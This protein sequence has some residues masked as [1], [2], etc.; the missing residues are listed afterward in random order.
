MDNRRKSLVFVALTQ[1][2][3]PSNAAVPVLLLGKFSNLQLIF[4]NSVAGFLLMLL[5][6]LFQK[7]QDIIVSYAKDMKIL[8]RLMM[9]GI[10]GISLYLIFLYQAYQLLNI[11]LAYTINLLWPVMT[12]VISI[13]LLKDKPK[14]KQILG[15]LI[16]FSGVLLVISEG[17]LDSFGVTNWWGIL[18][19]LTGATCYGLYSVLGKKWDYDRPVSTL[20]FYLSSMLFTGLALIITQDIDIPPITILDIIGFIWV[21]AFILALGDL[22]WFLALKYGNTAELS[23]IAMFGPF[24]AFIWI[25]FLLGEPIALFSIIGMAVVVVGNYFSRYVNNQM[26]N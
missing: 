11:Q 13:L 26:N 6:L 2:I 12:V 15:I 5:L 14:Q 9:M 17:R 18:S 19:A 16:A 20:F 24:I 10:T 3:W 1:I 8:S 7:R 4:F 23:S 22:F 21:G 25:Y